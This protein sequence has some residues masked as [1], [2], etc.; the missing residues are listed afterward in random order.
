[1]K[2]PTWRMPRWSWKKVVLIVVGLLVVISLGRGLL[3]LGGFG[4]GAVDVTGQG[5][6][7]APGGGPTQ[8]KTP[9]PMRT[10]EIDGKKIPV[11]SGPV[12]V[13]NPG[14]ARAGAT[15]GV[16]ASGFDPGA[17][18][19]V[20]LSSGQ[21]AKPATV[22]EGKADKN[23]SVAAQFT[24]PT[25]AATATSSHVVTVA[26]AGSDKVAKAE[27]SAQAGIA[28]AKLSANTGSPGTALTVD[29]DGFL[30]GERVNVYWGRVTGE[31]A[32][33]LQADPAGR[34]G[35]AAVKVGVGAVGDSMVVLIGDQSKTAATA[36]FML[37]GLYPTATATPYAVK[38][39]QPIA[40]SGKGFAPGERVLV[41]F[42]EV[43]GT[44]AMTMQADAYGAASGQS[45]TVPF[46]LSGEHR[47]VLTGEQS[48]ASVSTGF[49]VL[50]YSP[51]ARASTY[52]GLPGT[53]LNFYAREFAPGEAVHVYTGRG[54][55]S[56][57]DLVSAFRVDQKGAASA[58][59]S[60]II[61]GDAQGKLTFTLVGAKSQGTATATVTVD[62]ADGP[63]NVPAQPK[64]VLPPD[65]TE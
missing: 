52:G 13:L 39:T 8:A 43:S 12:A 55:N 60:Y 4:R 19:A 38:A 53:V 58:V 6:R 51:L 3:P 11:A 63:V 21:N 15:I 16:N 2:K 14:L 30:P 36:P 54:T 17:A 47:L 49:S 37:L 32:V 48:R 22:A 28:T 61:P 1:M 40:V 24:F 29:A 59:G 23:G 9:A 31:P 5:G 64:Y 33:T 65:L 45:F 34:I 35:K 57:G 50:P 25:A 42:N 41:Y 20:L 44:P 62:K 26:Q 18:V 7:D 46:G 56:S 10:V 27:L